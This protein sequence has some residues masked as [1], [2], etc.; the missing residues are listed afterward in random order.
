[1][2][3]QLSPVLPQNY[4]E[5]SYPLGLFDWF[6]ENL[7]DEPMRVG[8]LFTW[9]ALDEDA[10]A[11]PPTAH[12][13]IVSEGTDRGVVLDNGGADA[14]QG[15][16]AILAAAEDGARASAASRWAIADGAALWNDFAA[17]GA[18]DD[19]DDRRPAAGEQIGGAV[20]LTADLPPRG[21]RALRFALAWDFPTMRFGSGRTWYRRYTRFF[22]RDG[23]NAARIAAEGL[24]RE[25]EWERAIED[26]QAPYLTDGARPAAYAM[27][28]FNELYVMVDGGTAWE[29]GEVGSP[30]P[31]DGDGRF[32]VLECFDY[33]YYNTHDVLFYAS[34]AI[35]A[36]WPELELRMLRSIGETVA[37]DDPSAVTIE[38][39]GGPAVRKLSGAVAHDVGMPAEDPW[40]LVNGYRFRDPNTWKDLGT[41]YIL[42]LW[43]D[44]RMFRRL[45]LVRE[46]WPSVIA[47]VDY[48]AKSDRDGDGLLDHDGADQ[49]FDTWPMSGPS[50]Y[51]GGL[52]VAALA[53]V[54]LMAALVEDE[55]ARARVASLRERGAR[56]LRER[57]WSGAY[58]R[59]DGNSDSVMADQLCALWWCDATDL[60][61]YLA[62]ADA[63]RALEAIV[64]L[65]VRGFASGRLGA[66]NGARPDGSVDRSSEQSQE[67]WP[68]VTYTLAALLL[69]RGLD[70]EAWETALGAI[71]TTYENGFQFRTPEAWDEN[72]DFRA[73]IYL[74][75]LA[76]WALEHALSMRR[77][78]RPA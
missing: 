60:P 48:L 40:F 64:R 28:L 62:D 13:R 63:R 1:V 46:A 11:T 25:A 30:A 12:G 2:Q 36:L 75:P 68:G 8:I 17:D 29:D 22:G 18:L 10:I 39:T 27:A 74:R 31:S 16:F 24:R 21:G 37:I 71:R 73:S 78:Q 77:A 54:E 32:A 56:A 19:R 44:V 43:R 61:P 53:A 34:W 50:A 33:P 55:L 38:S 35:A 15:Q 3:R 58:L 47:V 69:A 14:P 45:D 70:A 4:R 76:L 20:A 9:Q 6:A 42:Q 65:N 57:L 41:K 51:A 52:W 7:T 67:V 26:W 59:Y 72:G 5:S 23:T 49:T 66:V